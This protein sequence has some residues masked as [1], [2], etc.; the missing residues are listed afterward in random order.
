LN[1][2]EI[3]NIYEKM[4]KRLLAKDFHKED[5][6]EV[7]TVAVKNFLLYSASVIIERAI[8]DVRDGLKPSQRRVLYVMKKMNLSYSGG[9]KKSARISGLVIGSLHPHGDISVYETMANLSQNWKQNITL[10]DGQGNWGSIDGDIPASQRYTEARLTKAS[11]LM[12]RDIEYDTVDFIKNY[13][14][15]EL[16]PT[17]LPSPLPM[18]MI[19]GVLKGSIAVGMDSSILP[20]NTTEVINLILAMID[21]RKNKENFLVDDF[22][23]YVNSPDLPTG[24][25]IYNTNNMRD[26]VSNGR[27]SLKI[28]S[29]YNIEKEGRKKFIVITEIPYGQLKPRL[30]QEVIDLRA[31]KTNKFSSAI[32]N[33]S[34]QSKTDIR[35]VIEVK[36]G[37]DAE[38]VMNYLYQ[39]TKFETSVSYGCVVISN[40]DG[41]PGPKECGLLEI[42]NDFLDHRFSVVERKFIFLREDSLKKLHLIEG[43]LKCIDQIEEVIKV[44]KKSQNTVTATK[45]LIKQ[46]DLSKEQAESILAMRLSKLTSIQKKELIDKKRDL[47]SLIKECDLILCSHEN[48]CDYLTKEI[49]S[50]RKDFDMKRR[51]EI[52]KKEDIREISLEIP[53]EDCLIEITKNGYIKKVLKGKTIELMENDFIVK[54]IKTNTSNFLSIVTENAKI[55]NVPIF[56]IPASAKGTYINNLIQSE[57]KII[58]TFIGSENDMLITYTKNGYVKKSLFSNYFKNKRNGGLKC[59]GL[60]EGDL[61]I[62]TKIINNESK[63]SII[64]IASNS[65]SIKFSTEDISI[66]GVGA[67]G[68]RSIKLKENEYVINSFLESEGECLLM[69][70]ESVSRIVKFK[71]LNLQ[72]RGGVGVLTMNLLKSSGELKFAINKK[73]K[74][75]IR[76]WDDS[77]EIRLVKNL[78]LNENKKGLKIFDKIVKDI[79]SF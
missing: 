15:L 55:Y 50:I 7:S 37:W 21:S 22:L 45:N 46:F 61:L 29:K 71:K 75:F 77:E 47:K 67:K 66:M 53:K 35:I 40:K 51:S 20:H 25:I 4:F 17:V 39:N 8:P 27:G 68:V 19:N 69:T 38:A 16:E 28:R 43:L 33:I 11:V 76:Y 65:K 49:L 54:T 6:A 42:M 56:D 24:G 48:K 34:D 62:G 52:G 1:Q 36:S 10:I 60:S 63:D 18:I 32:V 57:D 58:S 12:F 41:N 78:E 72:S 14:G 9:F 70:N 13:D 31:D 5:S 74:I 2:E 44:I 73:E 79:I 30:I 26:I 3:N 64:F 23:K 59:S